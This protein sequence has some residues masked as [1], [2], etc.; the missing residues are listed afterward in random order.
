[1]SN[2]WEKEEGKTVFSER[3]KRNKE[4]KKSQSRVVSSQWIL[5]FTV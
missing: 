1:M 4:K 3:N 5:V 2:M